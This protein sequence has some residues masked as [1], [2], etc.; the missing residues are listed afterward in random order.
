MCRPAQPVHTAS[1]RRLPAEE[2]EEL[3]ADA[4]SLKIFRGDIALLEREHEALVKAGCETCTG[5]AGSV[6]KGRNGVR[7]LPPK[8]QAA[9]AAAGGGAAVKEAAAAAAAKAPP[10]P[11]P[12]PAPAPSPAAAPAS[13]PRGARVTALSWGVRAGRPGS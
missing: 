12:A 4:Y 6:L 3:V 7:M 11:P 13:A 8:A 9:F 5:L 10:S 1:G 2:L